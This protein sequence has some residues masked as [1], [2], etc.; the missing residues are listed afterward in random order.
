MLR[1]LLRLRHEVVLL[2][3]VASVQRLR[4]HAS[5]GV[6]VVHH[7]LL[8]LLWLLCLLHLVEP[9]VQLVDAGEFGLEGHLLQDVKCV[10][11]NRDAV[12]ER[13]LR[14]T[15]VDQFD[16]EWP[17]LL[18]RQRGNLLKESG[19]VADLFLHH[20]DELRYS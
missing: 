2:A 13:T 18:L 4:V 7:H 15:R 9:L 19:I 17:V 16:S 14:Q 5:R 11:E 8:L 1:Q 20:A 3:R 10:A 12:L 6:R